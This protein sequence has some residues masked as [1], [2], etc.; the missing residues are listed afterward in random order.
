VAAL[1]LTTERSHL[2]M[3]QTLPPPGRLLPERLPLKRLPPSRPRLQV[4]LLPQATRSARASSN[5]SRH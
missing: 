2:L 5:P 4:R 1:R 3:P